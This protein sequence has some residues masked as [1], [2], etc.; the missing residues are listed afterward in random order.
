[1]TKFGVSF[2]SF[3]N[4]K[5]S[6]RVNSLLSF[7]SIFFNSYCQL[8]RPQELCV[9]TSK[10]LR[11]VHPD[12]TDSDQFIIMETRGFLLAQGLSH[13]SPLISF[14]SAC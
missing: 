4:W 11:A 6:C 10:M 13:D 7:T 8:V 2:A 9:L 12:P 3:P 5:L 1:M 14:R